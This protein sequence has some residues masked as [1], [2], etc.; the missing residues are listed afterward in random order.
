MTT[1]S[2][3]DLPHP[4]A[5]PGGNVEYLDDGRPGEPVLLIHAGVFGA[6]F[7]PLAAQPA[8]TEFG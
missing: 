6:W 4:L 3:P 1:P 2:H 8:L 5:L 7:Q